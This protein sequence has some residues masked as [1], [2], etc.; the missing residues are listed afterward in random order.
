[1]NGIARRLLVSARYKSCRYFF[2]HTWLL[3]NQQNGFANTTC[4]IW[5]GKC[6]GQETSF[7]RQLGCFEPFD[8]L[9]CQPKQFSISLIC[10][11]SLI[12][13]FKAIDSRNCLQVAHA[14]FLWQ[15]LRPRISSAHCIYEV[16]KIRDKCHLNL[17]FWRKTE[18]VGE[19]ENRW[20]G[21]G[22]SVAASRD[23]DTLLKLMA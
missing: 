5:C 20:D 14:K 15:P 12:F 13:G 18:G 9:G 19:A 8:S 21:V 17:T 1:M 23:N 22:E 16:V 4:H 7:H 2:C 11:W 6:P 10:L 3:R